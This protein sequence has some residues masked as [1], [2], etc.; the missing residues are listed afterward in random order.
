MSNAV[1]NLINSNLCGYE[2]HDED[3]LGKPSEVRS[4]RLQELRLNNVIS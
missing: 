2:D 1:A 3:I 4:T